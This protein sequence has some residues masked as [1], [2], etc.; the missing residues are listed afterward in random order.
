M[1]PLNVQEET[2]NALAIILVVSYDATS[3]NSDRLTFAT[4]YAHI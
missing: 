3:V 2:I 1:V 4:K